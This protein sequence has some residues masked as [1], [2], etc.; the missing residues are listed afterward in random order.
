MHGQNQSARWT[1]RKKFGKRT[2]MTRT[3]GPEASRRSPAREWRKQSRPTRYQDVGTRSP[4][5]L[6]RDTASGIQA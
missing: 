5:E 1:H 3:Y 4:T 2:T 6:L